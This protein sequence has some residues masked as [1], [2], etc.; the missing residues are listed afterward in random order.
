MSTLKALSIFSLLLVFTSLIATLTH[1]ATFTVTNRCSYTIWAGA[2]PGGGKQ[3]N[4]GDTWVVTANPGQTGGRIW[5]RTGCTQTGPDG[6]RCITGDCGGKIQ[7]TSYGQPP[8]TL[9]E[10]G[11]RQFNNLDFYDISLVDGFNVPMS[12]LPVSGCGRGPSCTVD[13][14][15]QCPNQL[16]AAGG[17]NNPCTVFKTDN[18]CCNSGSC[19]PTDFSRY[20]KG[21]CPDAYSY[22]KDDASSTFTCPSGTNYRV[23]FC[24]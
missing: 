11:L 10:Y 21:K 6:L 22:P 1:A 23:T 14:I 16:K 3:L 8:N 24:P 15:G 4:S 9:A 20:F 18:Y 13:L 19:G 2:V 7:C 12:F 5:P 17:C